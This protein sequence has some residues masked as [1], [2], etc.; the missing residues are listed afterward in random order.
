M[1]KK[2]RLL[3]RRQFLPII[4]YFSAMS[5]GS[6]NLSDRPKGVSEWNCDGGKKITR[7]EKKNRKS[8]KGV[9]EWMLIFSREIKKYETFVCIGGGGV[10][11]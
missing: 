5:T 2:A 7:R 11:F 9:S 6:Q 1:E 8:P 4:R 10:K 3:Y